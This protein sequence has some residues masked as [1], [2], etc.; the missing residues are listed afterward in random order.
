[1]KKS[2]VMALGLLFLSCAVHAADPTNEGYTSANS[3]IQ[4]YGDQ[5]GMNEHLFKPL[6]SDG[7]MMNTLDDSKQFNARLMC[8]SSAR[9]MEVLVQP[10]AS[11]D[12]TTL[13]INQDADFNGSFDYAYQ[14]PFE[15]SGVC[16]NGLI[17]CNPG[18]WDNCRAYI[19]T[20]DT[21]SRIM[22]E[23]TLNTNLGGCFCVNNSCGN[24]LVLNNASYV[25]KSIGGG[26]VGAL[27]R[28]N[29]RY[30]VSGIQIDGML[31]TYFGQNAGGC[32]SSAAAASSGANLE[33]YYVNPGTMEDDTASEKTAQGADTKSVH[34]V[35]SS[36]MSN[37][38]K[39]LRNC[40]LAR[41]LGMDWSQGGACA[42]SEDVEDH[43]EEVASDPS[44]SLKDESVDGVQTYRNFVPTG[45]SPSPS[46]RNVTETINASCSY[47]CPGNIF[48]PCVGNPPTCTTASGQQACS[49]VNPVAG[50]AGGAVI[51]S[52][53]GSGSR[54]Y[55]GGG[56]YVDFA[57]GVEVWGSVNT[58]QGNGI[59]YYGSGYTPGTDPATGKS[60]DSMINFYSNPYYPYVGTIYIKGVYVSGSDSFY[61]CGYSGIST[62]PSTFSITNKA[63][64]SG[65]PNIMYAYFMHCPF[66]EATCSGGY[67]ARTCSLDG[68]FD[69]W[70]KDRTY[71]CTGGAYDFSEIKQRVKTIKDSTTDNT[72]S[73]TY[74]DYRED[75]NGNYIYENKGM[76]LSG[77]NRPSF[78]RCEMACKTRKVREDNTTTVVDK[79]SD[80]QNTAISY[81]FFYRTCRTGSC[82][83]GAGEEIV[84]DC[85]CIDE[86]AEATLIMQLLRSAAQDT[87][88]SSGNRH[89][90]Q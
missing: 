22:L 88:C 58:C 36:L 64:C 23:E 56:A 11:G 52:V 53:W 62:S 72:S 14:V 28:S 80:F 46:C 90:L 18:T 24:N 31:A 19:W 66:P 82:P 32:T 20:S 27:H 59:A 73:M 57:A 51:S 48:T 54:L 86:F 79:K 17:N 35:V 83:A 15:V 5:G 25:I 26:V 2:F 42:L 10:G 39:E 21:A 69:W 45:L 87:I 55:F 85:Q 81:D 30:T 49:V 37:N 34:S 3:A 78:S 65:G 40:Y 44:C 89:M 29:S 70:R 7:V 33:Q 16:A 63:Y 9:F 60:Y 41:R 50:G 8:P 13:I 61:S 76:D 71:A 77:L 47:G 12:I 6:M 74:I 43:C 68:C 4:K 84:K 75:A 67:C 1:M 38:N